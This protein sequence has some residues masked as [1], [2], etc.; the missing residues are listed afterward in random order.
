MTV[1][2]TT[3]D[4]NTA[5]VLRLSGGSGL[6]S[7]P[8]GWSAAGSATTF[9]CSSISTGAGCALRLSYA[10]MASASVDARAQFRYLD[11]AG[12]QSWN[13]QY[14][15]F[16]AGTTRVRQR[17]Q[18]WPYICSVDAIMGHWQIAKLRA[19]FNGAWSVAFY[20]GSTANYAQCGRRAESQHLSVLAV[21][22]D[23]TLSNSCTVRLRQ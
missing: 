5:M 13:S 15:V 23:G 14:S 20:S 2:F 9:A 8:G 19:L 11:N 6:G 12:A 21:N 3:S 1:I 7:L 10:P 17:F 4:G 18:P 16:G 22:N